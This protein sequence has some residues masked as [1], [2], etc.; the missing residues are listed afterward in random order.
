MGRGAH[1]V[2]TRARLLGGGVSDEEI[3]QRLQSGALL[4]EYRGVYRVGHWAPS[5]EPRY[6]AAV[7]ACGE[8]ALLCGRAAGYL[9]GAL[10]GR[11]PPPEVLA[12]TERRV[13]G[14]RTRRSRRLDRRD[15]TSFR[16]I[17]VTTLART[18]VDLAAVLDVDDL[19]RAF[20]EAEVRH[21]TTPAQV[22]AVL[23]RRP[24]SPG[25]ARLRAVLRGDAPIIL[26]TLERRFRALLRQAALPPPVT[27]RPAGG[28]WVDCRWPAQRLTVELDSYRYHHSRHAWEQDRHRE[29]QARA[30]GD[31]FRRYTWTDVYEQPQQMLAELRTLLG[32]R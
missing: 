2:V 27:N 14:V 28:H 31:Q 17:P 22:E 29:R 19:A 7:L 20:H 23:G 32:P 9:F 16:R 21:R 8:G 15:A 11:A 13:K 12:A 30:R 6:M 4:R 10:R 18:L 1:G 5:L 3:R 26:S 25:A 24:N